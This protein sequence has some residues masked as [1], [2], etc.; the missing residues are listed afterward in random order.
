M[1]AA[2]HH[3]SVVLP[4]IPP[5]WEPHGGQRWA[6]RW[7]GNPLPLPMPWLVGD[8]GAHSCLRLGLS[9]TPCCS[10]AWPQRGDGNGCSRAALGTPVLKGSP[11]CTP[12]GGWVPPG[13][14]VPACCCCPNPLRCSHCHAALWGGLHQGCFLFWFLFW[15]AFLQ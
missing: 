9:I 5:W 10:R 12:P 3:L 1:L 6:W 2:E 7:S 11:P 8:V 4:P 14:L 13:Q 15:I